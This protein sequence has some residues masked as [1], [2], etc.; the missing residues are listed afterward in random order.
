MPYKLEKSGKGYFVVNVETGKKMSKLPLTKAKAQAQLKALNINV[1]AKE[2]KQ[3]REKLVA[4]ALLQKKVGQSRQ[5]LKLSQAVRMQE[6]A[7]Q[8]QALQDDPE[9]YEKIQHRHQ[10][11]NQYLGNPE[12][13]DNL[14]EKDPFAYLNVM[15]MKDQD[16]EGGG[17]LDTLKASKL[18]KA[19][20]KT[21]NKLSSFVTN[22]GQRIQGTITGRDNYPPEVRDIINKYADKKIKQ[23][24]LYKEPLEQKINMLTNVLSLGHMGQLKKKY[25]Y[26]EMYHLYMVVTVALDQ[27]NYA[28]I[29]IEKNEV[30]NMKENP[31][32]NPRARKMELLISPKFDYT[33]KQF[34][35]NGEQAMGSRYFTYDAFDNNCQVYIMSLISANPPLQQ[36]NPN[37][38][39]FIMQDVQG[40]KTELNPVTKDIFSGATNL[41]SRLN[42]LIK[43][44]GFI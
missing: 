2:K 6:Q 30:I 4:K 10:F 17:F 21:A 15:K 5:Q 22:I 33:F 35:D 34:L 13:M 25:G 14:K 11:I 40:I 12:F 43:G 3:P 20:S 18:G 1:V 38:R 31:T 44:Y 16:F 8:L 41:A 32:I 29:L 37:A 9:Q 19:L 24:C 39:N 23:I 36:D 27:D 26:D 7:K 42:V 28:S